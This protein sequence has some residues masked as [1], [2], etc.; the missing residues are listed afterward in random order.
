MVIVNLHLI[1]YSVRNNQQKTLLQHIDKVFKHKDLQQQLVDAKLRQAQELL[2][3]SEDRHKKE[4]EFV[5]C[6]LFI[7]LT[8][9]IPCLRYTV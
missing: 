1:K 8:L 4:K 7:T 6:S 9:Q 3:D 5:R 2:N